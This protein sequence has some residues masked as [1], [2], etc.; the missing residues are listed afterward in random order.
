MQNS[1]FNPQISPVTSSAH[2]AS[3]DRTVSPDIDAFKARP[4]DLTTVEHMID[5]LATQ[6]ELVCQSF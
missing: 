3:Q 6:S 2:E 4:Y 5:Q 1:L